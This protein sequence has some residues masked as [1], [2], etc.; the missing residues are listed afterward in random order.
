MKKMMYAAVFSVSLLL[1]CWLTAQEA[2]PDSEAETSEAPETPQKGKKGKPA[3]AEKAGTGK[4]AEAA[5]ANQGNAMAKDP[6]LAKQQK[7]IEKMQ[8]MLKKAKKNSERKRYEEALKSE[9]HKLQTI[10]KR[11]TDQLKTEISRIKDQIQ[12]CGPESKERLK[13][14]LTETEEKLKTLEAEANL[15]KWC[16]KIES[17]G[18]KNNSAPNPGSGKKGKRSKKK[19]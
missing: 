18:Q 6:D 11:K 3:K 12:V 8:A 5:K 1:P 2:E 4:T 14:K 16:A 19:K 10:T 17:A 15:E 7:K 9:Q 13:E